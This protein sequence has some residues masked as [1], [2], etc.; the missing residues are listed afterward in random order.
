[1]NKLSSKRNYFKRGD[2]EARREIWSDVGQFRPGKAS[3]SQG[4]NLP[5]SSASPRLRDLIPFVHS[6]FILPRQVRSSGETHAFGAS[7]NVSESEELASVRPSGLLRG[8]T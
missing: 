5:I 2:A 7:K 6:C 1:M 8:D 4:T 3:A